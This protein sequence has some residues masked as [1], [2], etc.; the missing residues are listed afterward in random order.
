MGMNY[1]NMINDAV[2]LECGT[3]QCGN[4]LYA[5][6]VDVGF[7]LESGCQVSPEF[8]LSCGYVGKGCRSNQC[9]REKCIAWF[10]CQGKSLEK[11]K[12]E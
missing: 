7:G 3:C 5:Y 4:P 1:P 12:D 6:F 10:F 9:V 2:K 11:K 8:C